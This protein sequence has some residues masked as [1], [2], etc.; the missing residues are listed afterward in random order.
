MEGSEDPAEKRLSKE[1]K[2]ELHNDIKKSTKLMNDMEGKEK[3]EDI[4][5]E[6]LEEA[7]TQLIAEY[8]KGV[9]KNPDHS[10]DRF[11][12]EALKTDLRHVCRNYCVWS[13]KETTSKY[14]ISKALRRL[15]KLADWIKS[16]KDLLDEKP[17]TAEE[18]EPIL[19]PM[20]LFESKVRDPQGRIVWVFSVERIDSK[21]LNTFDANTQIRAHFYNFCYM[22]THDEAVASEVILVEQL[23]YKGMWFLMNMIDRKVKAASDQLLMGCGAIKIKKIH[24]AENTWFMS[25]IMAIFSMFMSKKMRE[26]IAIYGSNWDKLYDA[27]GGTHIVPKGFGPGATGSTECNRY[28]DDNMFAKD[29]TFLD[30][31]K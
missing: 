3:K 22:C 17:I 31:H 26:R 13:K 16:H 25:K 23:C 28:G 18:C 12:F 27:I 30:K 15:E 10:I 11:P 14:N 1:D 5:I 20:G 21:T 7:T 2:K 29:L 19:K 9:A 8:E 24:M 4:L 6:D